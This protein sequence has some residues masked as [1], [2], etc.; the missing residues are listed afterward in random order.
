LRS[1]PVKVRVVKEPIPRNLDD[2]APIKRFGYYGR[3]EIVDEWN[4]GQD[5]QVVSTR[6]GSKDRS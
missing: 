1:L 2:I 3:R 5:M 4:L 6:V